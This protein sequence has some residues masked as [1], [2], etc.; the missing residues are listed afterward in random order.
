M[1]QSGTRVQVA[2]GTLEGITRGGIGAWL[3]VPYAAPP[4]GDL[5]FRSPEPVTPWPGVRSAVRYGGAATQAGHLGGATKQLSASV[6][7]D[8]LYLNVFSPTTALSDGVLRPVLFWIHGGRTPTA[9]VP[10]TTAPPSPSSAT[11]WSSP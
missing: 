10:C 6:G 11:W 8:C 5:R 3:G 1:A 2:S 9:A 4:V 7:E